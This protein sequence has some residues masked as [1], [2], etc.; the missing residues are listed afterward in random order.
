MCWFSRPQ[1]D[2]LKLKGS[3]IY[4][5]ICDNL[6]K[7]QILLANRK[8]E[9]LL[10]KEGNIE[11]IVPNV[12]LNIP[13]QT[14][15]KRGQGEHRNIQFDWFS[16]THEVFYWCK[17]E[18]FSLTLNRLISSMQKDFRQDCLFV[19]SRGAGRGLKQADSCASEKSQQT[20]AQRTGC[21]PTLGSTP[22]GVSF[23][24][25]AFMKQKPSFV[26]LYSW[27]GAVV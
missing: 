14:D 7:I 24:W 1:W 27:K 19:P 10:E 5:N 13:S 18:A 20:G 22:W 17:N 9:D 2:D 3:G 25:V 11:V 16:R 15:I 8:S 12:L 6:N 21:L 26:Y 23:V 4:Q